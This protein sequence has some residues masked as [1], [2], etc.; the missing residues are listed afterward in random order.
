MQTR[1]LAPVGGGAAL[2]AEED[3]EA[4]PVP[5]HPVGTSVADLREALHDPHPNVRAKALADLAATGDPR[6]LH[7]LTDALHDKDAGVREAAAKALG[8]AGNRSVLPALESHLA[9]PHEDEWVRLRIAESMAGLGDPGALPALVTL[10][11]SGDA[12]L[13]RLE[14]LN[15]LSRL[16]GLSGPALDAPDTDAAKE[17]LAAVRSWFGDGSGLRWD[18]KSGRFQ[19]K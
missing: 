4:P 11:A 9:D 5:E 8:R 6:V 1:R 19:R 12:G 16:A 17:R 14:A 18:S 13:T 2:A 10:A 3:E 15:I 7:E